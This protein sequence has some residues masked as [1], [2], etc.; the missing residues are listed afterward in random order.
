MMDDSPVQDG[1]AFLF[2]T[3][4]WGKYS[5]TL[6]MIVKTDGPFLF[7]TTDCWEGEG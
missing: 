2:P 7:P 3:R 6:T 1:L 4:K 5:P